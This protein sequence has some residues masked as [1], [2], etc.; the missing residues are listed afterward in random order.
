MNCSGSN[1]RICISRVWSARCSGII[2]RS[3]MIATPKMCAIGI[4][5]S[6]TRRPCQ[7]CSIEASDTASALASKQ[8]R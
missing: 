7:V 6:V 5:L 1:Q 2:N 3:F 8:D 4:A